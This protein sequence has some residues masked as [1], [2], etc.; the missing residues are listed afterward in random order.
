MSH[1]LVFDNVTMVYVVCLLHHHILH[2]KN[3]TRYASLDRLVCLCLLHHYILHFKDYTR[4]VGLDRL[5]LVFIFSKTSIY[6]Y[7]FTGIWIFLRLSSEM[8]LKIVGK[9]I[10]SIHMKVINEAQRN[11][12]HGNSVHIWINIHIYI[13][14]CMYVCMYVYMYV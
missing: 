6:R 11:T 8:S 1:C 7:I 13:S 9:L 12:S 2:F 10:I 14:V 4:H 3:Y 5:G